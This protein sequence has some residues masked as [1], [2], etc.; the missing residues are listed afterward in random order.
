MTASSNYQYVRELGRGAFGSVILARDV[1][2]D[3]L[4][5]VKKINRSQVQGYTESE[6]VNHSM[7]RHPHIVKFHQVF[8]SPTNLN[9]VMEF[10]PDG[11][12]LAAVQQE[13]KLPE[14]TARWYFQQLTCALDYCHK[15]GVANR[16][17]KLDNLLI[18]KSVYGR[19]QCPILKVCD[20]GY[21][22]SEVLQSLATSRVVSC[23]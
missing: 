18:D 12:L 13:G 14:L 17:I 1:S 21:A 2:S 4:V 8:L 20:W 19:P 11:S 3:S 22:K 9:I 10:V 23:I 16:D 7:L 15:K 5:A 6:L